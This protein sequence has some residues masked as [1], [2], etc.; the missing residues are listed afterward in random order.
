LAET[1]LTPTK[2]SPK[3]AGFDLL[4]PYDTTVPAR[5]KELINKDGL[6]D[7]TSRGM[8]RQN[9]TQNRFGAISACK[10]WSRIHQ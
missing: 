6:A 9:C 1:A 3:Y 8:L 2:E 4:S 5:G 10:N 7:K